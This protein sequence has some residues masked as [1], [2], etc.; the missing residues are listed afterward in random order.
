MN[1]K[2]M[3][4]IVGILLS[5]MIV[6]CV[7]AQED[8]NTTIDEASATIEET[9]NMEETLETQ[10]SVASV[11]ETT[12]GTDEIVSNEEIVYSGEITEQPSLKTY[13]DIEGV[14][15]PMDTL[16][17]KHKKNTQHKHKSKKHDDLSTIAGD[18]KLM[19]EKELDDYNRKKT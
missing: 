1:K 17:F 15:S 10:V 2:S 16:I 3:V 4:F 7:S 9:N 11:D 8:T 14:T 6:G 12:N 5:L 13:S 19:S 18:A